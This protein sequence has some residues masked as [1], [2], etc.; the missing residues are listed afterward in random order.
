M[1][2]SATWSRSCCAKKPRIKKGTD[3]DGLG[4]FYYLQDLNSPSCHGNELLDTIP[5]HITVVQGE[6]GVTEA[7]GPGQLPGILSFVVLPFEPVGQELLTV[8]AKEDGGL[9][10]HVDVTD[11]AAGDHIMPLRALK[12]LATSIQPVGFHTAVDDGWHQGAGHQE[13][14]VMT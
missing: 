10:I 8:S 6:D 1:R 4:H 9:A 2:R 11:E 7:L 13:L 3:F 12:S 14:D 5:S